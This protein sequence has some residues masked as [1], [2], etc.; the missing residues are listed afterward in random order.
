M[1]DSLAGTV[2]AGSGFASA[3]GTAQQA[4]GAGTTAGVAAAAQSPRAS[5]ASE[6]RAAHEAHVEP[7]QLQHP[8]NA[9]DV[10]R[11]LWVAG[12][13][14]EQL[15]GQVARPLAAL[16]VGGMGW[17]KDEEIVAGMWGFANTCAADVLHAQPLPQ[18]HAA[19]HQ[20]Q[21]TPAQV[22]ENARQQGPLSQNGSQQQAQHTRSTVLPP[23]RALQLARTLA[24]VLPGLC[25]RMSARDAAVLAWAVVQLR[26]LSPLTGST[27]SP[28]HV[29]ATA[30]SA[31]AAAALVSIMP[32]T[33][34]A[35]GHASNGA[36]YSA[37]GIPSGGPLQQQSRGRC[38]SSMPQQIPWPQLDIGRLLAVACNSPG[39][40]QATE[41]ALLL[42]ALA[43]LPPGVATWPQQLSPRSQPWPYQAPSSQAKGPDQETGTSQQAGSMSSQQ[44]ADVGV[45]EQA[46]AVQSVTAT[47]LSQPLVDVLSQLGVSVRVPVQADATATAAGASSR[48]SGPRPAPV[49]G[50]D[51]PA[52]QQTRG[53]SNAE[54]AAT[55]EPSHGTHTT[56]PAAEA[57]AAATAPPLPAAAG[58]AAVA[59]AGATPY[60]ATATDPWAVVAQSLAQLLDRL[61]RTHPARLTAG[62]QPSLLPNTLWSLARLRLHHA[63]AAVAAPLPQPLTALPGTGQAASTALSSSEADAGA[64]QGVPPAADTSRRAQPSGHAQPAAQLGQPAPGAAPTT[65][66]PGALGPQTQVDIWLAAAEQEVARLVP[67]LPPTT[68]VRLLQAAAHLPLRL[69]AHALQA[70]VEAVAAG[71]GMQAAGEVEQDQSVDQGK[72]RGMSHGESGAS[73][74][75]PQSVAADVRNTVQLQP[76]APPLS[77]ASAQP[78]SGV[79]VND[80]IALV[81]LRARLGLVIKP[82]IGARIAAAID[83]AVP[84]LAPDDVARTLLGLAELAVEIA[85]GEL[86]VPVPNGS[87]PTSL[88]PRVQP[89][90]SRLQA[91]LSCLPTQLLHT[92]TAP[93]GFGSSP[94]AGMTLDQW[95]V[96][97]MGAVKAQPVLAMAAAAAEGAAA[98]PQITP[99]WLDGCVKLIT[100]RKVCGC[101]LD[102][103]MCSIPAFLLHTVLLCVSFSMALI[104]TG[105]SNAR[106]GL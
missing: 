28:H 94:L 13:L 36:S 69:P 23:S 71:C 105:N 41:A 95:S 48:A 76:Q 20:V 47:H 63:P 58:T 29:T 21:G 43:G 57:A 45:P 26:L 19:S 7:V 51:Q 78:T 86:G 91:A 22:Q 67:V 49:A 12:R 104:V 96:V 30:R 53:Q 74:T 62:P 44:L 80:L 72:S 10:V 31:T 55:D 88:R 50:L 59:A 73:A 85:G 103:S 11:L 92:L 90:T 14:G 32:T 37:S 89:T 54:V 35:A 87:G 18:P 61:V 27:L 84:Q 40:L 99:Q 70:A 2:A 16:L 82:A 46:G 93:N 77:A 65:D 38:R 98:A 4:P 102:E 60:P 68:L 17:L 64:G 79:R 42:C 8:A 56:S 1:H 52:G 3:A 15:P 100:V 83:A 33:E 39:A 97:L 75:G 5:A 9:R 6:A 66:S 106:F 34:P 81:W 24:C 101:V 25:D